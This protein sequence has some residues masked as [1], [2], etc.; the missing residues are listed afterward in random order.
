[1]G[2]LGE[3]D[4]EPA[5]LISESPD[6]TEQMAAK[7]ATLCRAGDVIGLQGTLGAGKTCFVKGMARGLGVKD[8][9]EVTSPTFVLLK[10]HKGK[11]LTLHHFDAYRLEDARGMEEIGCDEIFH[12]R[13]VSVVEWANHVS[14]CLPPEHFLWTIRMAG[15]DRREFLLTACG[16]GPLERLK[17]IFD[18]LV[19]WE[20]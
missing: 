13:G 6:E 1:M 19:A 18:A 10:Q 11:K 9:D 8:V 5:K 14:S 7:F 4:V 12:S 3:I 16:K 15:G 17:G 20:E 2:T